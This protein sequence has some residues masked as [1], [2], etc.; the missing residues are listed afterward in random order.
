MPYRKFGNVVIEQYLLFR[1]KELT[2]MKRNISRRLM[3][4]LIFYPD[5]FIP[6]EVITITLIVDV[7]KHWLCVF[8][9][10]K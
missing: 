10:L 6:S 7:S 9:T 4:P 5:P 1:R 8:Y 2:Y 3:E